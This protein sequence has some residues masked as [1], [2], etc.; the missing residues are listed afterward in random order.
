ND[1]TWCFW[2]PENGRFDHIA[3]RRWKTIRFKDS[4]FEATRHIAPLEYKMLRSADFYADWNR[5]IS[6][7]PNITSINAAVTH[8]EEHPESVLVHTEAGILKANHVF[9]S[10]NFGDLSRLMKPYP[11]LQQHFIGWIIKTNTPVFDPETPVFMDFSV[12]Q[13]GNTRFMYV[14]PFAED[15]ALL[16]YTLFSS[17]LLPDSEY[18]QAIKDYIGNHLGIEQFQILDREKGVI[19][20]TC[21]DFSS[22]D[23]RRITYIGI[24]GGWAKPSTGYTFW[25]STQKT[26]KLIEALKKEEPLKMMRKNRFWF[27]DLIMLEVLAYNNGKGSQIFVAMF[28]KLPATLILRFLHEQTT[29]KE[30]LRVIWAC[31]KLMFIAALGRTM[32]KRLF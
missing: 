2:E 10:V 18:E 22:A 19:P 17:D 9:S 13:S 4:S 25:S 20:M 16:E 26:L 11:V 27:Y 32:L 23:S 8:L 30:E 24:A 29:F 28:R 15:E 6:N 14:L 21:N 1:R 7:V 31:P 3:H 5:R 12:P